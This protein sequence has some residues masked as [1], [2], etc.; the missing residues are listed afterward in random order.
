[1]KNL[2]WTNIFGAQTSFDSGWTTCASDCE[3]K[4]QSWWQP[5]QQLCD[6]AACEAVGH[7]TGLKWRRKCPSFISAMKPDLAGQHLKHGALR[8]RK[9]YKIQSI[10]AI[11][12]VSEKGRTAYSYLMQQWKRTWIH[13][14]QQT[15]CTPPQHALPPRQDLHILKHLI[16]RVLCLRRYSR[17]AYVSDRKAAVVPPWKSKCC[18]FEP[19]ISA[20]RQTSQYWCTRCVCAPSVTLSHCGC[21]IWQRFPIFAPHRGRRHVPP[22]SAKVLCSLSAQCWWQ[23]YGCYNGWVVLA[24]NNTDESWLFDWDSRIGFGTKC[25]SSWMDVKWETLHLLVKGSVVQDVNVLL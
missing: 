2:D 17:A 18:R 20:Q 7:R 14:A 1:M 15:H 19:Q 9:E 6:K 25:K 11:P 3:P 8:H 5:K 23:G 24:D 13:T 12:S 16:R 4:L 22:G 10:P 21:W